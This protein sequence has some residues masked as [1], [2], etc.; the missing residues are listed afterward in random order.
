MTKPIQ[1]LHLDAVI[2]N[3]TRDMTGRVAAVTGT[4]TG[5]GYFCARKAR[6]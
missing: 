2:G 3:H 5:T 1:T 4:T 6:G